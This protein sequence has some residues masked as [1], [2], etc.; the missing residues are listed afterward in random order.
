[1]KQDEFVLQSKLDTLVSEYNTQDK[2]KE[3]NQVAIGDPQ[4]IISESFI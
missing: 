1:M 4:I 3:G 2:Y